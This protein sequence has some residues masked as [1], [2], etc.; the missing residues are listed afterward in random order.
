[1]PL[2]G[3]GVLGLPETLERK[4]TTDQTGTPGMLGL[5]PQPVVLVVLVVLVPQ[6]QQHQI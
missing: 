2:A 3:A 6:E 5:E 1:M 4:V